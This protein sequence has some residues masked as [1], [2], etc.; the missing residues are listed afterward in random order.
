[1]RSAVSHLL[2]STGH[3]KDLFP[4][5]HT[6]GDGLV[7][8]HPGLVRH[9]LA[10]PSFSKGPVQQ[11]MF[12]RLLGD[13]V[14]M[15]EG[16]PHTRMRR[17]LAPLFTR[18]T[19]RKSVSAIFAVFDRETRTWPERSPL[20]LFAELGVLTIASVGTTLIA[21]PDLWQD[22]PFM[23]ARARIWQRM[24]ELATR[25]VS[26]SDPLQPDDT[27]AIDTDVQALRAQVRHALAERIRKPSHDVLSSLATLAR[28]G[29][30]TPRQAMDQLLALLMAAHETNAGA[31]Y[32]ALVLLATHHGWHERVMAEVQ[33]L[34]GQPP[35]ASH[36]DRL[37][38]TTAAITESLRLFPPAARQFRIATQDTNLGDE[39]IPAGTAVFVSH[40]ALHTRADLFDNP[41]SFDPGRWINA[42]PASAGFIPFGAGRH[43]CLGRHYA[44][45]ELTVLLAAILQ[46]FTLDFPRPA[47][48]RVTLAIALRPATPARVTVTRRPS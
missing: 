43:R 11:S 27:L 32:W 16:D 18:Q 2:T 42:D 23:K 8:N 44:T 15:L 24:N 35:T 47:D 25:D 41:H 13:S 19:A 46:R 48:I 28:R 37:P 7:V 21:D 20:D 22:G 4:L 36:L 45:T 9:V 6:G 10:N 31:L 26:V 29:H 38:L 12:R 3:D 33:Q 40:L 34:D 39:P 14:S 1:M 5:R 17:L 30:L